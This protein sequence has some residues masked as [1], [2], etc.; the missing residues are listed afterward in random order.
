MPSQTTQAVLAWNSSNSRTA[1]R[2]PAAV[3]SRMPSP[4]LISQV[5]I[6]P[7]NGLPW[8]SD[9][10]IAS[11]SRKSTLSRPSRRKTR[12]ARSAIGYPFQSING[13]LIARI[14]GLAVNDNAKDRVGNASGAASA[15]AMVGIEPMTEFPVMSVVHVPVCAAPAREAHRCSSAPIG[16]AAPAGEVH[17]WVELDHEARALVMM[18]VR[19]IPGWPRNQPS[20]ASARERRRRSAGTNSRNRPA[21]K[22]RTANS[23]C[24]SPQ[25]VAFSGLL[26]LTGAVAGAL[27][28]GA[29]ISTK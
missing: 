5:I 15:R 23:I 11:V 16:R 27:G 18:R 1:R 12:Q 17:A 22:W 29:C 21:M 20:A 19:L 9:A 4:S 26:I 6:A 2:D 14:I 10:R 13:R 3:K 8:A 7:A 28:V 25:R 24:E